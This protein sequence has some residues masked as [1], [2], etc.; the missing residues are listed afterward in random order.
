MRMAFI[1]AELGIKGAYYFRIVPAAYNEKMIKAIAELGHEIT[2][3]PVRV[4][5]PISLYGVSDT[6]CDPAYATSVGLLLWKGKKAGIQSWQPRSGLRRLI[7]QIFRV[8]R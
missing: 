2:R 4:G 7:S 6:L 3:L 5:V 8:F 1:E